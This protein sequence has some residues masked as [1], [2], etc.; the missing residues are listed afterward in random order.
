MESEKGTSFS[1]LN[2]RVRANP[3]AELGHSGEEEARVARQSA[4]RGKYWPEVVQVMAARLNGGS[5]AQ[6]WWAAARHSGCARREG[7]RMARARAAQRGQGR[8]H[9]PPEEEE[10]GAAVSGGGGELGLEVGD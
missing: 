6:R 10:H 8:R 5:T 3:G 2:E 1:P 7:A 4:K 9:G